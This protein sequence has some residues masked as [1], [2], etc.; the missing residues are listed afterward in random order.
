MR[1]ILAALFTVFFASSG[2]DGVQL[3]IIFCLAYVVFG[4]VIGKPKAKA[5]PRQARPAKR[6]SFRSRV[7][8]SASDSVSRGIA[9]VLIPRKPTAQELER[10]RQRRDAESKYWFHQKQADRLR[11]T[12]DGD[13]H[14]N[15]AWIYK[16]KM[17]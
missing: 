10:E 5:A 7:V 2:F 14:Q 6:Q 3:L 8:S 13:W 17:K 1:L 11:G 16:S 12:K 4:M 15:Q 9:S